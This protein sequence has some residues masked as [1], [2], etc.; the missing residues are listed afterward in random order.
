MTPP[1]PQGGS[2]LQGSRQLWAPTLG[3]CVGGSRRL[4][5]VAHFVFAPVAGA[6]AG[7]GGAPG[8]GAGARRPPWTGTRPQGLSTCSEG[9]DGV[10]RGGLRTSIQNVLAFPAEWGAACSFHKGPSWFGDVQAGQ[11]EP[12]A[13]WKQRLRHSWRF[14]GGSGSRFSILCPR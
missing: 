13:P 11:H 8:Q 5:Q 9:P 1:F 14:L 3:E 4:G 2:Q 7:G 10:G 6:A 12:S